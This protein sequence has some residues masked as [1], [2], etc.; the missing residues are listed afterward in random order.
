MNVA[1]VMAEKRRLV[2]PLIVLV[3]VT[4][5]LYALVV[6]PLGRQ[7]TSAQNEARVQHDQLYRAQAD[8]KLAKATVTGKQQAD[9]ALQKFYK[10]VLPVSAGV[11][12]KLT[13]ARLAQLAKQANV[14]LEHGSNAVKHEKGSELSKLTTTY[15]L[16]GDY[17]NVRRF[18]YSLETAPEF[19]V[20]ENVGL[21]AS[22]GEQQQNRA[23][24]MNLEI[25]TYF[26]SGDAGD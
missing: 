26:R 19:I 17:R 6:F 23:L 3:I 2:V 9:S 5:L 12:R 24:S 22:S 16:S 21:T 4:A 14:S 15:T 10:D 25:A 13:Y 7:V 8:Y 20:L 18:I 11:A 1:R